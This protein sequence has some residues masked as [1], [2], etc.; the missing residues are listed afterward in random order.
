[1]RRVGLRAGRGDRGMTTVEVVILAPLIIAFILVLVAFGQLVSGRGAVNG[2][3][4]DAARAGSLERSTQAAMRE[5]RAV[6]EAQLGDVC[7][8]G[9][10][11]VDA[12]TPPGHQPGTLFGIEVTCRVRG[13]DLL[14]VPVTNTMSGTSSSP[15]DPY[16]RSG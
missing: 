16:R 10:V 2:A 9:T 13:L 5:A 15:I 11:R 8:G 3:A 4:R 7:V 6:A 12:T 14:G 1:M